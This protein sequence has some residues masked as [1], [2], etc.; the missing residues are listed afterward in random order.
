MLAVEGLMF[1]SKTSRHNS[2]GLTV[3]NYDILLRYI[4]YVDYLLKNTKFAE[5]Q[6]CSS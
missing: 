1:N 4:F 3:G 6:S 5:E 2:F